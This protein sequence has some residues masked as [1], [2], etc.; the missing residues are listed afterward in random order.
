[1]FKKI[2]LSFFVIFPLITYS[3]EEAKEGL[4]NAKDLSSESVFVDGM[5]EYIAENYAKS[6]N[7]FEGVIKK[8]EHTAG[9]FHMLSK[10][11]LEL[12]EVNKASQAAKASL[13]IEK[14]NLYYQKFYAAILYKQLDYNAAIDLYKKV[15]KKNPF[16]ISSYLFLSD[17]YINLED[18]DQAIKLYNQVEKN[19]GADEEISHRK[20]MLYLRQN[21][22]D[23]AIEEGERL[24][25][26]QPLEPEYVLNQAQVMINNQKLQ[27]AKKLLTNYLIKDPNLA[28]GHILLAE[29]YRRLGDLSACH[30]ELIIAFQNK[31]LD[32]E[33]KLKVLGSYINLAKD[34]SDTKAIEN[35]ISLT[36]N[37]ITIAPKLAGSYVIMGDLLMK[38]GMIEEARIN[39]LKSIEFD[40]SVFEVWLAIVEL[41][42]KLNDSDALIRDAGLAAEYFP[43]QS[44]FWYHLGYGNILKRDYQEAIYALEEAKSLA[45]DNAELQK[46][47]LSLMGDSY[48]ALKKYS[49]SEKSYEAVL[50]IDPNYK[51]VLNNYSYFLALRA[52]NLDKAKTLAER[53]T[54]LYPNDLGF[55]D[56]HS[57][58]LF[59]RGEFAAAKEIIEKGI[60][61]STNISGAVYEHYGDILFKTGDKVKA[62]EQWKKAK[63][64]GEATIHIGQKILL[65]QYVE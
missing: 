44:F 16:D 2:Y 9:I 6:A 5:K 20:Q 65:Q 61:S 32:P 62:L 19:I 23:E 59:Q 15:I 29:I 45:F 22:V 14:E 11:Y 10:S 55:I 25:E 17:I 54:N 21:K 7:I 40:R 31:Q 33:V 37:L 27:D 1:M 58:V 13:D 30:S 47:I 38:K 18:Y 41:D 64:T 63:M 8:Y 53:L 28:E 51:E 48:N 3:Q 36:Q 42:T 35:A 12:N 49:D 60:E 46:H 39:Y 56:T 52:A 50:K 43:N 57:W 4:K 26:S 34:K 24:I